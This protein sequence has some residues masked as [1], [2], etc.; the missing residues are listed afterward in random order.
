M[1]QVT[2]LF[3][4]DSLDIHRFT[5]SSREPH[6]DP[7]EEFIEKYSINFTEQG[8]YAL[9]VGKEEYWMNSQ[10]VFFSVPN[11]VFRCRHQ[12]DFPQDRCFS[13]VFDEAFVEDAR[14]LSDRWTLQN[15][16]AFKITN[17]LWFLYS[18][19]ARATVES[20][21][22]QIETLAGEL[23]LTN[24]SGGKRYKNNKKYFEVVEAIELHLKAN[25]A[26][27]HTLN[28]L[29]HQA[30]LSPFHFARIF[31]EFTGIS[32]HRYLV[33]IRLE[34]ARELLMDGFGVTD[35][36][37]AVGFNNLSHFIRT[38]IKRYGLSPSRAI[39]Q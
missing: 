16:P 29:S 35:A 12:E 38:F 18:K 24:L 15:R 19:L 17:R 22:M 2:T 20:D 34:R 3:K 8:C 39:S 31:K 23:L 36:C 25:Y 14:N 1:N 10:T 32:P 33:K 28:G 37:F 5:H 6:Q 9:Q 21:S 27:E 7:R 13:V 26:E 11:L 4:S 30:G